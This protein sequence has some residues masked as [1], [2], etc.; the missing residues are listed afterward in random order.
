[1][2]TQYQWDDLAQVQ[3]SATQWMWYYN[4]GRPSMAWGGFTSKQRLAMIA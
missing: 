1:M 4:H 3:R 2:A